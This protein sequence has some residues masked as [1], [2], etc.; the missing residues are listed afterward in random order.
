MMLDYNIFAFK[1]HYTIVKTHVLY[2]NTCVVFTCMCVT[3]TKICC[4]MVTYFYML[5]YTARVVKDL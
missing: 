3:H 5:I 1:I 2:K 4:V